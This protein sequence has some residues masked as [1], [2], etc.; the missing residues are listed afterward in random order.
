M[1][2]Q[3]NMKRRYLQV[4]IYFFIY[5]NGFGQNH[6]DHMDIGFT[7][8]IFCPDILSNNTMQWNNWFSKKET[9]IFYTVQGT[10]NSYIAKRTIKGCK[11]GDEY[12]FDFD[13]NYSY[14]NPW[15][16]KAGDHMIFQAS[17][18]HPENGST[19]FNIWESKLEN[20]TWTKP[21]IFSKEVAL[22]TRNEGSPLL[23]QKGN[24]FFN[25]SID[26]TSNAD[27]YVIG[28]ENKKIT[29]LPSSVNSQNFEGDFYV[30]PDETY[31]IFSSYDRNESSGLSDLYIS[32]KTGTKWTEAKSLGPHINSG[33]QDFSPYVSEDGQY[34]IFTSSRNSFHSLRP[35]FNYYIVKFNLQ[36]YL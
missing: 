31:I 13:S 36:S 34:L 28:E 8:K 23:T 14:S 16:N 15:V 29:P 24:L 7:P 22:K 33:G 18:P 30:D 12:K 11:L 26:D 4:L 10:T 5:L 19:D 3:P 6:F 9:E 21:E 25:V 2:M 20:N 27:I 35:S 17:L 32:F 1:Q